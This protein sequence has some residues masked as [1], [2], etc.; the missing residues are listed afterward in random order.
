MRSHFKLLAAFCLF[1]TGL[2]A[3][4]GDGYGFLNIVNLIPGDIPADVTL[5]GKKLVPG[6]MKPADFTGWF[7]IPAG[8]KSITISLG[9]KEDAKPAI[10]KASGSIEV[11]EGLSNVIAVFLQPDP[12]VK[13][14]GTPYPPKIRIKSFPAYDSKGFGL[15]FVSTS[16]TDQRF[17]I[18]P[19]R[20]E[21]KPLEP[22]RIGKWSGAGFEIMHEGKAVGKTAGSSEPGSF[23]LFVGAGEDG[24]FM[25]VLTRADPQATPPWMKK[26]EKKK[27][28]TN[29]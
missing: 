15:Q 20:L 23:Y 29:Q 21:S 25:T 12:R 11:G 26:K 4:E 22:I 24:G 10:A 18:G 28:A 1:A 17:Q 5:D 9:K 2:Q 6:G 8:A 19:L 16:A 27:P 13:P 7:V 3:Q 14:D